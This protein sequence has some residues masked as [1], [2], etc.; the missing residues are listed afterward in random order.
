M[1]LVKIANDRLLLGLSALILIAA[2]IASP[3][4]FLID[5]AVYY[6]GARAIA[7][8]GSL[9]LDN[10]YHL[11]HSESLRLSLLID[12]PQGLTP[13]YPAGSAL[14]AAPLL[15]FMGARAFVLINAMSAILTLFT[16]RKICLGQFKSETVWRI[17][18][19]LLVAGSFWLEYAVGIWPHMLSTF[20]AVQAYWLALRHLESGGESRR[21]AILAGL[22]AGAGILFRLDAI[23]AVPA[24]GMILLIYAPRFIRS[25]FWFSVGVL[26]SL[27]LA[28]WFS[29]LK[30]GSANPI[31]YGQSGGNTD[32][33]AHLPL[34]A[35]LCIAVGALVFWRKS[36]WRPG[37]KVTIASLLVFSAAV[38]AVPAASG[39]L[40][41]FGKGFWAL[42][43][44]MRIVEDHRFGVQPGPGGTVIFWFLIKKALGQSMPWIGL[45]AMLLTS[46]VPRGERRAVV[47]LLI[48][49][50][51]MTLPYILLSWH[52][53]GCS[54]MRY[55]LPVLPALSIVCARIVEELW[56]SVPN[57][58]LFATAGVWAALALGGAWIVLHPS[59]YVGIYQIL[60]T[61]VLIATAIVA[62]AAGIS[63]RFQQAARKLTIM[64]F[65]AGFLISIAAALSDFRDSQFRKSSSFAISEVANQLPARSLIFAY[66]EWA[67]THIGVNGGLVANREPITAPPDPKLIRDALNAG[68]R[69]FITSDLFREAID[70]PPGM[71]AVP[72]PYEYPTGRMIEFRRE[73]PDAEPAIRR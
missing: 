5:D 39:L 68:Y 62:I 32:V 25:C 50:M 47:T 70:V 49:T 29:Y 33:A 7:E 14:L 72:T 69:V 63:G 60:S 35:A 66:P 8:Y 31:S 10:G 71:K 20:F 27:A 23:L 17:T 22:F 12:G 45:T 56:R 19:L 58:V 26:P 67:A 38:I 11:F 57:A 6:L 64:L 52:G 53:G 4:F 18:L 42:V 61:W 28:S 43:V 2:F 40:L 21:D 34:I 13:Q 59:G 41:K 16:V 37:R 1:Q 36:G 51:V 3:G 9:G 30:F 24:I 55:F 54:N 48:F 65:A 44:D 73:S 15:P 46:G